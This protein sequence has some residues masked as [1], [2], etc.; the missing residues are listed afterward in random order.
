ML[1]D[2]DAKSCRDVLQNVN[3]KSLEK[4]TSPVVMSGRKSQI[5]NNLQNDLLESIMKIEDVN[6][7]KE[8]EDNISV[9]I[10]ERIE[11]Q[12]RK[13]R[14]MGKPADQ[15]RGPSDNRSVS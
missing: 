7:R 5:S 1:R 8:E 6:L 14:V 2:L 11:Q 13:S 9:K 12:K 10:T 4:S 15:S 3:K